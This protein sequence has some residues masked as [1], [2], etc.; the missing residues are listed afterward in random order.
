MNRTKRH[1]RKKF[2]NL[3]LLLVLTIGFFSCNPVKYV[4]DNK[5]LLD[6]TKIEV[7][8]GKIDSK[9][10]KSYL[11]QK[12]NKRIIG[13]RFHL[14]IYNLS[15]KKKENGFNNWLRKIGEE[16]VIY[17]QL[18]TDKT[19]RQ[20]QLYLSKKGYFDNDVKS[21]VISKKKKK[22]WVYY[23]VIPNEPFIIN[24]IKYS[25]EDTTITHIIL[26]DTSNCLIKKDK[27]F[28]EDILLAERNRIERKMKDRGYYMFSKEYIF[29]EADSSDTQHSVDILLIIKKYFEITDDKT[30]EVPHRTYNIANVNIYSEKSS[31]DE[32]Y[33]RDTLPA[34][35][36]TTYFND[37]TY[38]YTQGKRKQVKPLTIDQS[39][40]ITKD[41][42]YQISNIE[43]T[44]KH[45]LSLKVYKNVDINFENTNDSTIDCTIKL[46]PLKTQS[47]TTEIEGTNSSGNIG[48]A[49]NLIYQ[50]KNLFNGAEML[51]VR[52]T[53]AIEAIQESKDP[54]DAEANNT[55]TIDNTLE[56]GAEVSLLIPRF[57]LPIKTEGFVKKY[58]PKTSITTAYN[59]HRR[60]EYTRTI[61]NISFGYTWRG[62]RFTTHIVNPI[63]LNAVK[64]FDMNTT[65]YNSLIPL[66]RYSY[67]N[68][69]VATSNYSFIYTNQ[70]IKKNTDFIYFRI[71]M[72]SAGNMFTLYNNT[73]GS[74]SITS[75][76][77]F[78]MV[79]SQFVK[80]DIDFRYSH[81]LNQTDNIVYRI[82]IGVGYPYGNST[83]LPF[84]K[85]YFSGGANS[86]R[87]WQVRSLGP[88]SL[89]EETLTKYPNQSAD[90][91]LEANLEYRFDLF[92][93]L[94]GAL[95]LDAGNIWE[96]I[97]AP[98]RDD[99]NFFVIDRNSDGSIEKKYF[100]PNKILNDMAVGTG[101]GLRF[102]FSFFIFRLDLGIKLRDP[103]EGTINNPSKWIM[104]HESFDWK[105]DKTFNFG[106][107]YPF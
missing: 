59:Y 70:N 93:L 60:P 22:A 30:I 9:E 76:K 90:I 71:N 66:L 89:E 61:A 52:F 37:K 11:K 32:L 102:D 105:T 29:Y 62:N 24:K 87:A 56:L 79:Y 18:L 63:E 65:F 3:N 16:P 15:S 33:K 31:G 67:E 85:K 10:L 77:I 91:K 40:F 53:G 106:I 104:S 103:L 94:K 4:P 5:Q 2:V 27:N 99:A 57:L 98:D 96:I 25:I 14:W 80:G 17:D 45:L 21:E 81:A 73:F 7:E 68:H 75:Y 36:D 39:V 26:S 84:E 48:A 72:E 95:F 86:I 74:D 107:G 8:S 100:S 69:F 97:D 35:Y 58:N 92:W 23:H 1:I 78:G 6:K 51:N 44:Y 47:Y 82:F 19:I 20:F 13:T 12:P 50:H 41:H 83:V 42:L 55:R 34:V 46:S 54:D 64:I 88:G 28:D 43:K 49:G 101:V 38:Y